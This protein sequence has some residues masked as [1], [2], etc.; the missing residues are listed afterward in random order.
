MNDV[1]VRNQKV[2]SERYSVEE[3]N[4][5]HFTIDYKNNCC[6]KI[7]QDASYKDTRT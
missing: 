3:K 7:N 5:I 6:I 4:M 1:V 2:E